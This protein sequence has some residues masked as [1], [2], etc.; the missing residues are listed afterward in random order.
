MTEE[1]SGPRLAGP[2]AMP[3]GEPRAAEAF[4]YRPEIDGL[5]AVAVL[6]VIAHHLERSLLP[7]GFLGVDIFF[8]ISGFVI[9]GSLA[10]RPASDL[11]SFL[12]TFYAR[13]VRRLVPALLVCVLLTGLLFSLVNPSPA[14]NLDTGIWAL[15]GLSNLSLHNQ[16]LDYFGL[17]ADLNPFTQTWSL[18]VEE[19]FYLVFPLLV[20]CCGAAGGGT[21]AGRR[22]LVPALLLLS[23]ASLLAFALLLR[24]HPE[25]AYFL[26]P[27]RFWE[28]AAGA[29]LF[30]G[31]QAA[32]LGWLMARLPAG[33]IASL[34]AS[35]LLLPRSLFA[36]AA[37]AC[38]LLTALLIAAVDRPGAVSRGL[39]HP[40]MVT[41]GRL[42]YSLYLWH[43][44][45]LVLSR[46]TI[47]IHLWTVPLQLLLMLALA[48]VSYHLVE[49]PWRQRVWSAAPA[50]TLTR[51]FGGLAAVAGLLALL[52][53]PWQGALYAGDRE[54]AERSSWLRANSI[55]GTPLTAERCEHLTP[56]TQ[57]DCLLP[58]QPGRPTV[59]LLGDSH[60]QHLYPLLGELRRREGIGVISLAPG[61]GQFPPF[62]DGSS[63]RPEHLADF[64]HRNAPL[65]RRGDTLLLSSFLGKLGEGRLPVLR[66]WGSD[67]RALAAPLAAQGVAVVVMLPLPEFAPPPDPYPMEAC[68]P[69]WFRPWLEPGCAIRLEADREPLRRRSLLVQRILE[70]ELAGTRNVLLFDGFESLCGSGERRCRSRRGAVALYRDH[71]HVTLE[72]SLALRQLFS[73]FL[74]REGLLGP[75]TRQS[76]GPGPNPETTQ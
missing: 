29:L 22:R 3:A 50:G 12:L 58:P 52:A 13:R 53:G 20:W 34:L 43:W 62:S 14:R 24:S 74:A 37:P 54:R 76:A 38:V 45:V 67:V 75:G 1:R 64:Y 71:D 48:W 41:L 7:S 31:R 30:Q 5:R 68:L 9:C 28:L 27:A 63:R 56:H 35:T 46:W 36:L 61:G 51:G 40:G 73:A 19:Q 17:S 69:E 33:L 44:S 26:M 39:R 10:S 57:R 23:A 72:G 4:T 47:G 32:G 11:R 59:M 70:R 16:A 65:L 8:V 6:A 49:R 18:G 21:L 55:N 66:R 2:V 25:S 15:F 42:S 60:A